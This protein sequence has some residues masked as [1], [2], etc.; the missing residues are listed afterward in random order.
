MSRKVPRP[1]K[2]T[3]ENVSRL[4]GQPTAMSRLSMRRQAFVRA[5]VSGFGDPGNGGPRFSGRAA[6]IKAGY[7]PKNAG[8]SAAR[9]LSDDTVGAAIAELLDAE[10]KQTGIDIREIVNRL[11]QVYLRCM[12]AV[13]VY[14]AHGDETGVWRFSPQGAIRACELLGRYLGMWKADGELTVNVTVDQA[15]DFARG[16]ARRV[17]VLI[18]EHVSSPEERQRLVKA[19]GQEA[20]QNA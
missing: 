19:L 12:Q 14:D 1:G 11:D 4:M 9:L 3:S 10:L 8:N 5:Y 18:E 20:L 7:S 17:L 2:Y 15:R 16:F 13:P 6:A